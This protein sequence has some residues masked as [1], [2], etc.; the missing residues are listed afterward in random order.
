MKE[1]TVASWE[2]F[3]ALAA[4]TCRH[5]PFYGDYLFRGQP[6][7]DWLLR[8]SLLRI[9]WDKNAQCYTRTPAQILELE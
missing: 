2:E 6:Q 3:A 7:S 1:R 5:R 9:F 8:P 4:S